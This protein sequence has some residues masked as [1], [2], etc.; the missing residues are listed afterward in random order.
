M[1]KLDVFRIPVY[2]FR[3]LDH[4][5]HVDKWVEYNRS[6]DKYVESPNKQVKL[7]LP[8]LHRSEV[9]SPLTE[10]F[11]YCLW[12]VVRDLGWDFEIDITS[13]WS[14]V[15][16]RG[17][18]H[19]IHTHNNCM[20]V[21]TYYMHSDVF[22][23]P[24]TTFYNVMSDFR[25]IKVSGKYGGWGSPRRNTGTSW[26]DNNHTIPFEEGKLVIYPGWMRHGGKPHTGE[27]RHVIAFNAMPIGQTDEDPLQRYHYA[28]FRDTKFPYD[29][30]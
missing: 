10:F 5:K 20:F 15:Q 25:M 9:F 17:G 27:E 3:F 7:S 16:G 30:E 12:E 8:N 24:G 26:Y 21:G 28:D 13:M 14:T 2:E 23:S 11:R 1:K 6:Y 4:D 22:I 29:E 19:H 18:Q